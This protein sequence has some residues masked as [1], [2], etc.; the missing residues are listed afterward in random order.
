MLSI[1]YAVITGGGS[2][3]GLSTVKKFLENSY[4]VTVLSR[5]ESELAGVASQSYGSLHWISTDVGNRQSVEK[6][7]QE[8]VARTGTIDVL[9]N[10]AGTTA[11]VTTKMPL[12]ESELLWDQVINTNLKGAF[13]VSAAVSP[14]LRRPGG[15][16]IN[17]SSIA[18]FSGG[19]SEGAIAY[20]SSKAGVIGLT[21]ALARELSKEKITVNAIAPGVIANT[22]FFKGG[23]PESFNPE[24]IIPS[25]RAGTPE[26]IATAILFLAS[27]G[28]DYITGEVLNVNGG[29]LFK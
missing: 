3:I 29:W 22:N 8:I 14:Y 17:I 20:A 27:S 1:K 15:R 21:Y 12:Q 4:D 6:A 5:T 7:I 18:A 2:G 23:L 13:L 16:I 25:G 19:S 9:V 28:A 10:N 26:D 24:T 11:A